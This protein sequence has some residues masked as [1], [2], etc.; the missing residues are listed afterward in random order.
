MIHQAVSARSQAAEMTTPQP[1]RVSVPLLERTRAGRALSASRYRNAESF[2]LAIQ[3]T[4]FANSSDLLYLTGIVAQMALTTHLLDVGFDDRWCVRH[5]GLHI[6]PALSYANATGL[7]YR[8]S[9][10]ERLAVVLSPYSIWRNPGLDGSR[11]PVPESLSNIPPILRELLDHVRSVT[12]H[13][14]AR[15][16]NTHG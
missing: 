3:E 12:G 2:F 7:N 9:E 6:A 4:R 10:F 13:P 5:V 16:G 11:P 1:G 8:S 14:R 15:P